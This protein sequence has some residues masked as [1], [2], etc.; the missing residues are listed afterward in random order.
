MLSVSNLTSRY[1]K[2]EALRDASF[3]VRRGE[4]VALVGSNGAGK[5]TLLRAISGIQPVAS[6]KVDFDGFD[7][8]AFAAH[9][10]VGIGL[11]HVPQGRQ[12]FSPLTVQENLELGA[13]PVKGNSRAEMDNVFSLFPI[14][15]EF[16]KR[17][18][19]SLSGGQQQMLA[20]GRAL[21]SRPK[22]LLLDEPSMGLAPLLINQIFA[23]LVD[24]RSHGT[25][26]LVVE[27]NVKAVLEIA[28]RGYVLENGVITLEGQGRALLRDPRVQEAYLGV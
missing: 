7:L 21:M 15:A 17:A 3:E 1:G 13:W 24:I 9:K 4:I 8:G 20:I 18:A 11:A 25:T 2:V 28:D 6:G 5:T 10:R 23:I 19:G 14:L 22:M 26:V 12:I 27:Q 16:R